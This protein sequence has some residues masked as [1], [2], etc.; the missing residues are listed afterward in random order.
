MAGIAF[1]VAQECRYA[2][3]GS[4][5]L[6]SEQCCDSRHV[7]SSGSRT[8][9]PGRASALYALERE[10]MASQKSACSAVGAR[11]ESFDLTDALILLD[12]KP[13]DD[14][15]EQRCGYGSDNAECQCGKQYLIQAI[16]HCVMKM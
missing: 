12:C 7:F 15:T 11:Q 4:A 14:K 10:V 9:Y 6:L 3:V 13:P 16:Y 2:F 1:P 5:G 8:G